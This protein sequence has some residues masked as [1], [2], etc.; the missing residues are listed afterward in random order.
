MDRF[1]VAGA[2]AVVVVFV[3]D[4]LDASNDFFLV[5]FASEI[6]NDAFFDAVA[7][8]AF[9]FLDDGFNFCAMEVVVVVEEGVVIM[10]DLLD[11]DDDFKLC[12]KE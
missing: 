4:L 5:V 7:V 1:F 8:A 10:D 11:D 2:A 12:N 3:D 6:P 9:V